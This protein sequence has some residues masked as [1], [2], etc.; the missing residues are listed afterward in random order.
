LS[1][2]LHGFVVADT[3]AQSQKLR[4]STDAVEVVGD[5]DEAPD[6]ETLPSLD[7]PCLSLR[8]G[9]SWLSAVLSATEFCV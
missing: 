8:E 3:A 2:G 4:P 5:L 7:S 6:Q 1:K 9:N